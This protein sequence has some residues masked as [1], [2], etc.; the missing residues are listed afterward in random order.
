MPPQTSSPSVLTPWYQQLLTAIAFS[1]AGW[2][3][4][5][6]WQLRDGQYFNPQEGLGYWMGITG[7]SLML[8]LLLYPARKHWRPMRRWGP[9]RYWF[10]VH[11]MF[12][13]LGPTLILFHS[14]FS[15][16]STNSNVALMC[17][18]LVAGSGLIGR[19]LYTRI[20]FGLYGHRASLKELSSLLHEHRSW[21]VAVNAESETSNTTASNTTASNTTASNTTASNTTASNTTASN[22]TASNTTASN[23]TAS[24]TTASNTTAN[25]NTGSQPN[26]TALNDLLDQ[27]EQVSQRLSDSALG[28]AWLWWK[29]Q[30]VSR[31]QHYQCRALLRQQLQQ[32][33]RQ[34]QWD[35][36]TVRQRRHLA[37]RHLHRYFATARK[38]QAF[39]FYERLFALWHVIH[40]PF[41]FM[42]LVSGVVHVIAVHMY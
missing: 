8:A 20:H 33:A 6:G 36:A 29:T 31:W 3:L 11:M 13:I 7:G 2:I 27:V 28:S 18:L 5:R 35:A 9:I 25:H 38:V 17:M 34:Q 42:L 32:N 41:F 19:F 12:G 1:L 37:L 30:L 24:N 39:R 21:L 40:L 26:G 15:L 14:N 4:Y 22:T 10:R 16:G 23:T